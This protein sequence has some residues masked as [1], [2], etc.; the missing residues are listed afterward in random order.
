MKQPSPLQAHLGYWLRF[1]SN[2]VSET[3]QAS[4]EAYGV[5]LSDWVALRTLYGTEGLTQGALTDV[6]GM[7]KGA[8][9]KVVNRL[10]E[11]G[12]ILRKGNADD[13][14]LVVLQLSKAGKLLVPKLAA[15]ADTNDGTFFNCLTEDEKIR[16]GEIMKKIVQENGLSK[17]PV[18]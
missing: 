14:R 18:K 6:L 2:R 9:S 12:L 3:F 13:A 8:V 1:V 5:T 7:T 11:K 10:D 17:I 15:C 16:L 4:V